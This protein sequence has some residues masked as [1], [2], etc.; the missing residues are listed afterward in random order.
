MGFLR[1]FL[2]LSVVNFHGMMGLPLLGGA[3]AVQA[4]FMIS[5]F[6]MALVLNEKYPVGRQGYVDFI[7]N[8]ILRIFPSY[9][10]VILLTV[11]LLFCGY[12]YYGELEGALHLWLQNWS[13]F[14]WYAKAYLL[15]THISLLGQDTYLFLGLDGQ[16]GFLFDEN[17]NAHR[18]EFAN[19]MLMP[20]AWSLSLELYFYLLAPFLVRRPA[21]QLAWIIVGSIVIRLGLIYWFGWSDD[22]WNY[23]F[24]PS[25]LAIFLCGSLSYRIYRLVQNG[26]MTLM[27]WGLW[28]ATGF[29]AGVS[30]LV[31]QYQGGGAS[32]PG[33]GFVVSVLLALPFLFKVSLNWKFDRL[34]G[35]LSYPV[36]LTHMMVIWMFAL[37]ETPEGIGRSAGILA[38]TLLIS[39][40]IYRG[41]DKNVDAFRHNLRN[42]RDYSKTAGLEFDIQPNL[43][44]R[45]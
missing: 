17:F 38:T 13:E 1:L 12:L 21:V 18:N 9:F 31:N 11:V 4:F 3:L 34:I 19:F 41:V 40:A 22:P 24:F 45:R 8:R 36:Y 23:R 14:D 2:A 15:F 33:T 5:G 10:L 39:I 26:E 43:A 28:G 29:A 32:L 20:Q 37:L 7:L 35:E 27:A 44:L 30:L 6:Y 25:E 16:G 42:K